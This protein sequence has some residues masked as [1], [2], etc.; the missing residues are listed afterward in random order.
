M[1]LKKCLSNQIKGLKFQKTVS[2]DKSHATKRR[3]CFES[4]LCEKS[5]QLHNDLIVKIPCSSD[6]DTEEF[7]A[8]GG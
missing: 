5:K 8:S 1:W 7:K 6:A 3:Q 2:L 4:I